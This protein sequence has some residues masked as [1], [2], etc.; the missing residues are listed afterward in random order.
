MTSS[1]VQYYP[2]LHEILTWNGLDNIEY[3]PKVI[4]IY[5]VLLKL[6]G[7]SFMGAVPE[8]IA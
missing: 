1:L 2:L 8:G 3:S 7:C 6:I 5:E 4:M